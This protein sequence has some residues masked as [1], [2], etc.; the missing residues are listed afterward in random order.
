MTEIFANLP[1]DLIH[2]ILY[3]CSLDVRIELRIPPRKLYA[4][5]KEYEHILVRNLCV[6]K[7]FQDQTPH[8]VSSRLQGYRV[9]FRLGNGRRMVLFV[10]DVFACVNSFNRFGVFEHHLA[11]TVIEDAQLWFYF[12]SSMSSAPHISYQ[13]LMAYH[14]FVQSELDIVGLDQNPPE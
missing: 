11:T 8:D 5:S 4:K 9:F 13:S 10:N 2:A 14:E 7:S 6:H 3:H 12:D 1:M